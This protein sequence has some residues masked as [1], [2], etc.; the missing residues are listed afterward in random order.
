MENSMTVSQKILNR[1]N[2]PTTQYTAKGNETSISK[3]HLHPMFLE[4]LFMTA[5]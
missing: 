5:I 2:N 4:A 3:R 1:P